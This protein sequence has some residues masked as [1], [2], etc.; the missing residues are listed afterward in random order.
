MSKVHQ[1]KQTQ[2]RDLGVTTFSRRKIVFNLDEIDQD[3]DRI[4]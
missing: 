1:V 2:L 4:H 3:F